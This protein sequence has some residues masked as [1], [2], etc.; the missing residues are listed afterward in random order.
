MEA[1]DY[2]SKPWYKFT[3]I[4]WL[5]VVLVWR[6]SILAGT[7]TRQNF[8]F[9]HWRWNWWNSY[10]NCK[11]NQMR[12]VKLV[13]LF[14]G[15]ERVKKKIQDAFIFWLGWGWIKGCCNSYSSSLI[16]HVQPG[17]VTFSDCWQAYMRIMEYGFSHYQLNLRE[18]FVDPKLRLLKDFGEVWRKL[19][20]DLGRGV[21]I[22]SS[23]WWGIC[24]LSLFQIMLNIF[25]TFLRRAANCIQNT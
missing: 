15:S 16:Y 25:I 22:S 5:S 24:S 17:S 19:F 23:K 2:G 20:K 13:G 18:Y 21:S 9:R 7:G 4:Y 14:S 11:Y 1:Q 12:W 10:H 6:L 8:R 3:Y